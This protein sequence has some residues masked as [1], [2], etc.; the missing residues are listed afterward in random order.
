MKRF[1]NGTKLANDH[2]FHLFLGIFNILFVFSSFNT[3]GHHMLGFSFSHF[4]LHLWDFLAMRMHIRFLTPRNREMITG[5]FSLYFALQAFLSYSILA[6]FGHVSTR[7]LRNE[8]SENVV[9]RI[10]FQSSSLSSRVLFG[11][12]C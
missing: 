8:C 6:T 9:A 5:A 4:H 11:V 10:S 1:L 7:L 3:F 2:Y 12:H